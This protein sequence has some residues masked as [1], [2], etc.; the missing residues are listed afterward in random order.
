MPQKSIAII[1]NALM[2]RISN[3]LTLFEEIAHCNLGNIS[4]KNVTQ[5]ASQFDCFYQVGNSAMRSVFYCAV[6]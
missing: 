1:L 2:A 5:F 6:L 4:L 3:L